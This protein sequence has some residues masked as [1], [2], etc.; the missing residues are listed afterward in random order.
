MELDLEYWAG[1]RCLK[2]NDLSRCLVEHHRRY[3]W[4]IKDEKCQ[5]SETVLARVEWLQRMIQPIGVHKKLDFLATFTFSFEENSTRLHQ[6]FLEVSLMS[7]KN[8]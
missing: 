2:L 7:I 5:I 8:H 4:V 6:S 1:S 3:N